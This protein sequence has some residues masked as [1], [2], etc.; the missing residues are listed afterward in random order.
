MTNLL[1]WN[2]ATPEAIIRMATQTRLLPARL[3]INVGAFYRVELL[4]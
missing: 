2:A 1:A 4:T 3:T